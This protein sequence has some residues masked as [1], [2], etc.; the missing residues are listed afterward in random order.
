MGPCP[1]LV[2][3][4]GEPHRAGRDETAEDQTT[5][6]GTGWRRQ[7]SC[8]RKEDG[9]T[10][11]F[12]GKDSTLVENA[13][14]RG[15]RLRRLGV[16][17]AVVAS[18]THASAAL[19][20]SGGAANAPKAEGSIAAL[21]PLALNPKSNG[22]S[23]SD[24]VSLDAASQD[25]SSPRVVGSVP[26][27][28]SRGEETG[29]FTLAQAS[30]PPPAEGQSS[31][32]PPAATT[33]V[34]PYTVDAVD[35]AI[36]SNPFARFYAYY[37]AE[38][39]QSGPPTDPK[40]PPAIRDGWPTV[41]Q[42][43]P[44]MPFT[45]WPYGGTTMLGDNRTASV[46][47]PLM[48]AIAHTGLG[49]LFADTGVQLYGWVDYGGNI[50]S[51]KQK[52]GNGPA[53]YDYNPNNVQLDQAVLY[54]E[55]TPDTV[56][57]DHIDWGFRLSAIY[58]E[59]YRYTTAY[60]IASYQLLK[61]NKFLGYDFPMVYGE[62]W[63]PKVMQGLMIR[64]GRYISLP[65]IEA[66]L[67]PNNYMY[68]HS[69]TYTLDNYTNEGVQTTLAVT[70]QIIVQLG[71]S[72]GTEAAV[73]HVGQS[74]PNLF[75]QGK[76][77]VDPLYPGATFK[78]DPGAQPSYTLCGRYQSQDGKNDLNLCANAI[79]N[80][81]WGYNNLQWY[82]L[83][84]YH[85]FDE[86]WHISYEIYVEHQSGV[87]NS[88]NPQVINIYNNGGT[89]FSPQYIPYNAPALAICNTAAALRC[90]AYSLGTVF[91]LNYSPNKLNNFSLRGEYY[92]DAEGQRTGYKTQYEEVGLG[93]QHWFSPQIEIRPEFT[94][95]LSD[96]PS[97]DLGLKKYERVF[98]GDLIWHF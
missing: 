29:T 7:A 13:A 16:A 59:N 35:K 78:R 42:S 51:S 61:D 68:T 82:G 22:S 30:A 93:W 47:S 10:R 89:P 41:P 63:I 33:A 87:P 84:A 44:P 79:N 19:A 66:Q 27:T 36:G 80:G 91:Y 90:N 73:W 85:A 96:N 60:G 55:R 53:A 94:Y 25:A 64:V 21:D 57:T 72:I 38:W 3:N 15:T 77:G 37:F 56:Q 18:L 50:S 86:H 6:K 43:T 20:A 4:V 54:L 24:G 40:A 39:G 1:G 34:D 83:T 75:V 5:P 52:F 97:F 12:G 70:K 45:D 46:D 32:A 26:L 92:N 76:L 65:D 69:I 67:A 62:I 88:R 17:A 48:V 9:V 95:Y 71:V 14:D 58:G 81:Q 23:S 11:T 8:M 49:K 31:T 74:L 98:S 2:L 28:P